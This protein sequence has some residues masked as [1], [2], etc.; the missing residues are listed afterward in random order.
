[1][2]TTAF[3]GSSSRAGVVATRSNG[4]L[5]CENEIKAQPSI[6]MKAWPPV[7]TPI[8]TGGFVSIIPD[9]RA[10]V[11][12]STRGGKAK[13]FRTGRASGSASSARNRRYSRC[14]ARFGSPFNHETM[15]LVQSCAS[16]CLVGRQRS[17]L[18]MA[19]DPMAGVPRNF[20]TYSR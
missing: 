13:W 16:T 15:A 1:M 3:V 14:A 5:R 4:L 2:K 9:A 6:E 17:L 11:R 8:E 19:H 10:G 12:S 18:T 20:S 7:S